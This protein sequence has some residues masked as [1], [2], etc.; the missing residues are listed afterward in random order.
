MKTIII[1]VYNEE[2]ILEEKIMILLRYINLH[3]YTNKYTQ[4]KFLDKKD[5]QVVI[6]DNNSSDR[7]KE[8]SLLLTKKDK[9]IKY[10]FISKKGRGIAIREA[11]KQFNSEW[12]CYLDVDL[13]VKMEEIKNLFYELDSKKHDFV[14]GTRHFL[15]G[16]IL[17]KPLRI[18]TSKTY[19]NLARLI[20]FN[21]KIL[22]IQLGFKGWNKKVN[23]E[24]I[25]FCEDDEWFF[26]TQLVYT[27]FKKGFKV[28]YIPV[29]YKIEETDR[30]SSVKVF[31]DAIKMVRKLIAYKMKD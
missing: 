7:T 10:L 21:F 23:K 17:S 30:K 3:I 18:L 5:Y 2:K 19:L 28:K 26:D 16:K 24:V 11:S 22:D 20:L 12:Y 9:H 1:P 31:T 25:P 8:I 15:G 14:L 4:R 29:T 13:P 6:C 27:C